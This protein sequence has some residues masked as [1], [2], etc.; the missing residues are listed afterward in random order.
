[1]LY[2]YDVM[3]GGR[4]IMELNAKPDQKQSV[5]LLFIGQPN[6]NYPQIN[7]QDH[8]FI[9][10][11]EPTS[12]LE[13]PENIGEIDKQETKKNPKKEEMEQQESVQQVQQ[14]VEDLTQFKL[15]QI[16]KQI[17]QGT[18][19][20]DPQIVEAEELENEI[21]SIPFNGLNLEE[22]LLFI[23]LKLVQLKTKKILFDFITDSG[24][25]SGNIMMTNKEEFL[26]CQIWGKKLKKIPIST[27]QDVK[28]K[29]I[30]RSGL[31]G[32]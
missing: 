29:G 19:S 6:F 5:P 3:N 4:R 12:K 23:K 30:W 16:E 27:I 17:D 11:P 14:P 2:S 18:D 25:Y 31:P 13:I 24:N 10:Q 15:K 28:M 26:I 7:M 20:K 9:H 32:R 21:R 8:K 22:K 1:M